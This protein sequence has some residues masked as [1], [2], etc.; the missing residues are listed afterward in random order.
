MESILLD[1]VKSPGWGLQ[2]A[3]AEDQDWSPDQE[4]LDLGKAGGR[5]PSR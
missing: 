2:M 1:N 5:K 3:W 4:V